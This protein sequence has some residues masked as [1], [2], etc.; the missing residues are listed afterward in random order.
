MP[1]CQQVFGSIG[2]VLD[3]VGVIFLFV[4]GPPQPSLEEGVGVALEDATPI[5][6]GEGKTV[7]EYN[8]ETRRRRC[9]Y[10]YMSK[11]GLTILFVGFALQLA[12]VW[13]RH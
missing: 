10:L 5:G 13:I 9:L 6:P 4:F 12:A 11:V 2:L 3:M 1:T 8:L 7:A